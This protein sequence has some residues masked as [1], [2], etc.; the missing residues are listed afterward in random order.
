MGALSDFQRGD[1]VGARLAGASVTATA[2]LL[3]VSRAAICKVL[4]AYTNHMK[5]GERNSGR[6]PKL[7]RN[8]RT[9]KRMCLKI[10]ELPQQR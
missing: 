10:I 9:L 5:A 8:R 4:M 2:I 3:G 7:K 1:T 6:K